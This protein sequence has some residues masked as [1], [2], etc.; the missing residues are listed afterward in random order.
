MRARA[1]VLAVLL[2]LPPLGAQTADLSASSMLRPITPRGVVGRRDS[3]IRRTGVAARPLRRTTRRAMLAA[4]VP[5][6]H[7]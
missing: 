2:I 3:T 7:P 4:Q 1:V 5:E 6:G